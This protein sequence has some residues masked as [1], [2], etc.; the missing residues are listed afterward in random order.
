MTL[1][2]KFC[3]LYIFKC[4]FSSLDFGSFRFNAIAKGQSF[5]RTKSA[6]YVLAK[7]ILEEPIYVLTDDVNATVQLMYIQRQTY[8]KYKS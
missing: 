3:A 8:I 4:K 6:K 5:E 1:K 7:H 2:Y